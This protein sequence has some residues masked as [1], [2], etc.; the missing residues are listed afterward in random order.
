MNLKLQGKNVVITG[1]NGGLGAAILKD[2]LEEGATV[3]SLIR[4]AEKIKI[5]YSELSM[6]GYAEDRLHYYECDLLDKNSIDLQISSIHEK[7]KKIDVLVN[8]AGATD[9]FPFA[10]QEHDQFER[11]IELNLKSPMYITKLILKGMFKYKTGA[12]INISSV[13]T[14]KK[15]RGIVTYASAK[16]GME[17]FTRTLALEVGRK[18]IRVNCVRPGLIETKMSEGIRERLDEV[19]KSTVALERSG[20]ASEISKAV[21]FLASE[22]MASYITGECITVDGGVY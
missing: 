19:L 1:A 11:M 21:L 12:I 9:E 2:F 8:C 7:F 5:L 14:V 20:G 16:A 22:K 15:G 4:N 3:I 18:G 13:S 17:S 10:I 6:L